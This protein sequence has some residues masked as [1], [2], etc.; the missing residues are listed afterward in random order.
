MFR[1]YKATVIRPYTSEC[2][3]RKLYSCI[4]SFFCIPKHGLMLAALYSRNMQLFQIYYNKMFCI[5]SLY[6]FSYLAAK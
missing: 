4:I 1:L 6:P 2:T 5:E 3:G